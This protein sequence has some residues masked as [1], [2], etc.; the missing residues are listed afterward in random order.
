M[1]DNA[2][3]VTDDRGAYSRKQNKNGSVEVIFNDGTNHLLKTVDGTGPLTA[4]ILDGETP[5]G[6]LKRNSNIIFKSYSPPDVGFQESGMGEKRVYHGM[7]NVDKLPDLSPGWTWVADADDKVAY[8]TEKNYINSGDSKSLQK[9]ALACLG[10][11]SFNFVLSLI[12]SFTVDAFKNYSVPLNWYNYHEGYFDIV[13]VMQFN[14]TQACS[15]FSFLS[16][17]YHGV[18]LMNW[19]AHIKLIS[20]ANPLRWLEYSFSA[21]LMAVT[22]SVML[23]M[24]DVVT[25]LIIF[26]SIH[27]TMWFG[28]AIELLFTKP[29]GSLFSKKYPT[30]EAAIALIVV[31]SWLGYLVAASG[32]WFYL[33]GNDPLSRIPA[34]AWTTIVLLQIDFVS[35]GI[36]QL[37]AII[38]GV[39]KADYEKGF[40][41]LSAFA[42][43]S[44]FSLVIWGAVASDK[45]LN[46]AYSCI[47]PN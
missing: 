5:N 14:I 2:D 32:P 6:A 23:G 3:D 7:I 29:I 40:Y 45:W 42:K 37:Y 12:L 11:H 30:K 43:T 46:M 10:I 13:E 44:L 20:C 39:R 34:I 8:S 19:D 21:A 18:S 38:A 47:A 26:G 36:W 31:G 25:L 4:R 22:I 33:L 15:G 1:G 9:W 17:V 41:V 24:R 28:L 27:S 16:A 35:F